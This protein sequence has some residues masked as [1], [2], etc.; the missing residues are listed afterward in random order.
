MVATHSSMLGMG[1]FRPFPI[2]LV[3]EVL[4]LMGSLESGMSGFAAYGPVRSVPGPIA[5]NALVLSLRLPFALRKSGASECSAASQAL[6]PSGGVGAMASV[7]RGLA[8]AE[9]DM[10]EHGTAESDMVIQIAKAFI[11]TAANRL[12]F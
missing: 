5:E 12:I 7:H 3:P 9:S 8:A 10:D 11:Q 1:V 6:R 4:E 2:Y